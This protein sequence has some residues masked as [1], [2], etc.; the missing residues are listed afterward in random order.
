MIYLSCLAHPKLKTYLSRT[1]KITEIES[2]HSVSHGI[3]THPD[4]YLCDLGSRV[5]RS[6][7]AKL[8]PGYPKEVRY[9]AAC[10]GRYFIHNLKYTDPEL[11]MAAREMAMTTVHV[12]Q[13]YAKCNTVIVDERSVITSD[14]GMIGPLRDAG[15]SVLQVAPGQVVLPGYSYGFL[16][17]TSGKVEDE[18]VFHGNLSLHPD[19]KEIAQ[20][21]QGRGLKVKFFKDFPLTDIGSI[22][23]QRG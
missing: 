3:G 19:H 11:P 13:G 17:G 4:L 23:W 2:T 21:I 14:R 5:F 7:P 16:G 6:D 10:T 22:L 8:F 12:N 20:F 9:N 15:M 1:H 18:I